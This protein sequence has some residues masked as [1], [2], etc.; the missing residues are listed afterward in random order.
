[1]SGEE[2]KGITGNLPQLDL[3]EKLMLF[4]GA[5]DPNYFNAHTR[6]M[7]YKE[8]TGDAETVH[9]VVLDT[10]YKN[11]RMA[12]IMGML[13]AKPRNLAIKVNGEE[14]IPIGTAAGMDKNG[15]AFDMFGC[16][17][18]FQEPG[19]VVL[20]PREGNKKM[21]VAAIG[22][23]DAANAMGFSSEGLEH[24]LGKISAYRKEGGKAI[25]YASIC[26]LPLSEENAIQTAMEEMK[27]LITGLSPYVDGFVWNPASPNTSALRLLRDPGVFYDTARLMAQLAPDKLRLVKIWPYEPDEK[28]AMLQLVGRF[29]EGG[30]HGVVTTNTRMFPKDQLPEDIR[31]KW[32]HTSFGMSGAC[33]RSYRFRSV[34]DVR[35]AFPDSVIIATGGIGIGMDANTQAADDAYE[36]ILAGATMLESMTSSVYYG[37]GLAKEIMWGISRRLAREGIGSLGA[38]QAQIKALAKDGKLVEFLQKETNIYSK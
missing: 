4:R 5:L 17:Y 7:L 12:G 6:P 30:G 13:F 36:T 34:I 21:R 32:G 31:G 2:V 38:L 23:Y 35:T 3:V 8:C 19:T 9:D 28:E 24:F 29:M 20:N 33:L 1:M 37:P 25:I 15:Q 22:K 10:M 18:G 14:V 27:T 11:R 16:I 26:G